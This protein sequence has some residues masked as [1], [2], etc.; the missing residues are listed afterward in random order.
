MQL[1]CKCSTVRISN[2]E[3]VGSV[4]RTPRQKKML[5]FLSN[6][7]PVWAKL[8]DLEK[9]LPRGSKVKDLVRKHSYPGRPVGD[10]AD[11]KKPEKSGSGRQS[12]AGPREHHLGISHE[13]IRKWRLNDFESVA[14]KDVEALENFEHVLSLMEG[15]LPSSDLQVE[16]KKLREGVR[17]YAS[18]LTDDAVDLYECGRCL[19]M[20][21]VQTQQAIDTIIHSATPLLALAYYATDKEIK[22]HQQEFAGLYYVWMLR[23]SRGRQFWMQCP[24]QVRYPVRIGERSVLRAKMLIP[25]LSADRAVK[26]AKDRPDGRLIWH[27]DGFFRVVP[28]KIYWVF[29]KRDSS[30]QDF[31]FFVTAQG[32]EVIE[33]GLTIVGEY[34]TSG[35]DS[36]QSTVSGSAIFH[37]LQGAPES[38]QEAEEQHIQMWAAAQSLTPGSAEHELLDRVLAQLG[39]D[40]A[41]QSLFPVI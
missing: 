38:N 5:L 22:S 16:V 24:V 21:R 41:Q 9:R 10:D 25:N 26:Q 7:S 18:R 36:S 23:K 14:L 17:D 35:Q 2:K 33:G 8:F 28:P 32:G 37:R 1:H 6:V 27:Y 15:V 4:E 40:D 11:G 34:L 12:R 3:G 20:N 30:R 19:G 39:D 13:T 31:V 29:E